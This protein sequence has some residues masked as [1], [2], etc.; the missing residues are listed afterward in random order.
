[1]GWKTETG[2]QAK[3][4]DNKPSPGLEEVFS[5]VAQSSATCRRLL[6]VTVPF[7]QTFSTKIYLIKSKNDRNPTTN[8]KCG[9][10]YTCVGANQTTLPCLSPILLWRHAWALSSAQ[11]KT[12]GCKFNKDVCMQIIS[13]IYTAPWLSLEMWCRVWRLLKPEPM[14]WANSSSS[15]W[16]NQHPQQRG[17]TFS[18]DL[19]L[20]LQSQNKTKNCKK[21]VWRSQELHSS[22]HLR[23]KG[24]MRMVTSFLTSPNPWLSVVW[25]WFLPFHLPGFTFLLVS[26][27]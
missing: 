3:N 9:C 4:D 12:K 21:E 25:S 16:A 8:K 24:G 22:C 14:C 5:S 26:I 1:M 19:C 6:Y 13:Q 11:G 23:R 17:R 18:D 2:L 15:L 27:L 10:K 7:S 20:G